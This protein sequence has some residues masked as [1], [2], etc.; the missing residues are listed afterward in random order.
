MLTHYRLTE[1]A[2]NQWGMNGPQPGDVGHLAGTSKGDQW[3]DFS[4]MF[5]IYFPSHKGGFWAY[6]YMVEEM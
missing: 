3:D 5:L 6:D 1:R 4:D 2:R